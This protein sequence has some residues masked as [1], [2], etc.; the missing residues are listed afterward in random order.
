MEVSNPL[1][2]QLMQKE[3]SPTK[4]LLK[5]EIQKTKQEKEKTKQETKKIILKKLEITKLKLELEIKRL[6]SEALK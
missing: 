4:T 2:Q 3:I 1:P 5:I 6:T